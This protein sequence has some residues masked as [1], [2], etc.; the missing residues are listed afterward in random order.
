M[1]ALRV[2]GNGVE[3]DA[4]IRARNP[5]SLWRLAFPSERWHVSWC[6]EGGQVARQ[7]NAPRGTEPTSDDPGAVR[8]SRP[9][10]SELP[11]VD[12]RSAAG[13]QISGIDR[14]A[15]YGRHQ[16]SPVRWSRSRACLWSRTR[17]SVQLA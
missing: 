3:G 7:E 11:I 10:D 9:E 2:P 16:R 13:A 8:V 15:R 4:G 14:A 17:R 5:G 6:G 12:G 1:S